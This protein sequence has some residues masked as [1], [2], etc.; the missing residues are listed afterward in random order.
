MG[1]GGE[2]V[3]EICEGYHLKL[4]DGPFE[5]LMNELGIKPPKEVEN[6]PDDL[7]LDWFEKLLDDMGKGRKGK[8]TLKNGAARNVGIK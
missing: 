5:I 3:E 1:G 8:S 2:V 4:A 6:L 7:D